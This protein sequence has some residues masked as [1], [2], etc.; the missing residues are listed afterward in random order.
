MRAYKFNL[1]LDENEDEEDRVN[2]S[3]HTLDSMK[4]ITN[5]I[6]P[7]IYP[8]ILDIGCGEGK[9]AY[10]LERLGYKVVG[11][12]QGAQN[13]KYAKD[14]YP[15]IDIRVMDMHDLEFPTQSFN[16][17]YIH[18]A[19]E[20]STAPFILLVEMY[21]TLSDVPPGLIWVGLPHSREPGD[22]DF[23]PMINIIN[24]HHRNMLSSVLFKSLFGVAFYIKDL[25][26]SISSPYF[27][28][29]YLLVKKSYNELHPRVQRIID[30]RKKI[31]G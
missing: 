30:K 4:F 18:H 10:I 3:G 31:F 9:E 12:T 29:S 5:L 19:F 1:Y 15:G 6:S 2:E 13:L 26:G 7:K 20:H 21:C 23:N 28:Q 22:R 8:K 14:N 25:S 16:A 24:H 27:D 11:I 17:I